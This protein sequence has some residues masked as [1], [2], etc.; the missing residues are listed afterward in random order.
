MRIPL[1][2]L[3]VLAILV[4]Y[5]VWPIV[6]WS[7]HLVLTELPSSLSLLMGSAPRQLPRRRDGRRR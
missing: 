7:L 4:T 2:G 5:T 3:I 6:T 1:I